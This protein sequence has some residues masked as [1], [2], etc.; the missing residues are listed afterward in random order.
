MCEVITS[1]LLQRLGNGFKA[2]MRRLWCFILWP[3]LWRLL[4][5]LP[6]RGR[7][8]PIAVLCHPPL[9]ATTTASE[10]LPCY[11]LSRSLHALTLL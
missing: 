10:Q 6:H 5:I 1:L 2:E 9:A 3:R 8:T 7:E 4:L 11:P